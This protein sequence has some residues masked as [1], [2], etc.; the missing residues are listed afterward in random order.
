MTAVWFR[1]YMNLVSANAVNKEGKCR[2]DYVTIRKALTA[3]ENNDYKSIP[4]DV[5]R[6]FAN[7][8]GALSPME[9]NDN[10]QVLLMLTMLNCLMAY[11]L[12][13]MR[14]NTNEGSDEDSRQE[15]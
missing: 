1:Q 5:S 10:Q 4:E 15:E 2:F 14:E 8:I 11:V 7:I 9:L 3:V 12:L 6:L 13:V